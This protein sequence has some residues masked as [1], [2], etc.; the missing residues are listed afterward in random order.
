M[1]MSVTVFGEAPEIELQILSNYLQMEIHVSH[2]PPGTSKW[3][4]IEHRFFSYIS[5]NWRASPLETN[6]VIVK[7]LCSTTTSTG[8]HVKGTVDKRKYKTVMKVSE[9]EWEEINIK[10]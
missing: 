6:E 10:S 8:L 7:L 4:K 3:N 1:E 9:D 2:F 5:K